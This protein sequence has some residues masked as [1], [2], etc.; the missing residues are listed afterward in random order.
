MTR[1]AR[2][3][4]GAETG[5]RVLT[6][7]ELNRALLA[8]QLLVER[9][10]VPVTEARERVGG[11]QTQ[12]APSGYLGLWARLRDVRRGALTAALEERRVIQATLMRSTIHMVSAADYW[13][14]TAGTMRARREWWLRTRRTQVEGVNLDAA[15]SLVRDLLRGHPRRNAEILSALE[16]A[17]Y[18]R[19]EWYGVS[20]CV[21]MVRLPPSGTWSRRRADLYGLADEWVGAPSANEDEGLEL[22]VRRYLG[23]FGPAPVADIASWSGVPATALRP[24]LARLDLVRDSDGRG[25]ELGDLPGLPLP[26][27]DTTVPVRLLP[28]WEA[29]LLVHARRARILPEVYRPLV[30]NTRTPHSV[31]TILVDGQVAGTWR[32][33][34]DRVI[35]E[36]FERLDPSIGRELDAESERLADFHRIA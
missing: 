32:F 14:L 16:G 18:S 28:V 19:W 27:A 21:E 24:V 34:R 1:T 2:G 5:A 17:G 9:G 12:Y 35:L 23:G 31:N 36:P 22:L 7:R 25:R 15:C 11:L 13:P 29:A 3:A 30:F 8:R 26:D 10:D 6:A 20:T 4:G 33:E